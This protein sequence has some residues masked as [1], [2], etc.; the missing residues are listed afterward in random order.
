MGK[1]RISLARSLVRLGRFIQSL[2]ISVMRPEDLIEFS[3]L[4]YASTRSTEDWS[5]DGFIDDGLSQNELSLLDETPLKAGRILLLGVGG[6]REAIPLARRGYAVTGVDYVPAMIERAI[7]SAAKRGISIQGFVQDI[8]KLDVPPES[9]DLVWFSPRLYS[10]IPTRRRRIGMMRRVASSLRP[11]GFAVCQFH[12][13][14]SARDSRW[15][16]FLRRAAAWLSLGYREYEEGDHLWRRVEFLHA[17][18]EERALREEFA[19]GGLEVSAL[20]VHPESLE[21]GAILWKR[22]L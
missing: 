20:K 22:S 6:G 15:S 19:E 16:S 3:R 13:D 1:P 9:F 10:C 11:G 18:R 17:F 2:A 4:A 7:A 12:W 8:A 14:P 21:G 5:R